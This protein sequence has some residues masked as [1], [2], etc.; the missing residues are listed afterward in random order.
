MKNLKIL[1]GL[2]I[3][4]LM[5]LI[6]TGL[7]INY[8]GIEHEHLLIKIGFI[9]VVVNI[10]LYL[11]ILI[12]SVIKNLIKI[13]TEK[14]HKVIGSKFRTKLVASFLGLTL[15]PSS[16]LF[17]LSNQLID[18][19]IDKWF[20]LEVQRPIDD[21]MYIARAFYLRE[22][23]NILIYANLMA[24]DKN[25][26]K[27]KN[28]F[29]KENDKYLVHVIKK[30]DD[31]D[32]IK[33]AFKGTSDTEIESTKTGDII[34]AVTPVKDNGK[35]SFVIA[36]ETVVP[37]EIVNKMD[38]IRKANNEYNQIK[39]QQNP[40]RFFY[41]LMLTVA[42][43]IIVFLALW[44]SLRIAKS[45]TV[46]IRSL[47]EA[48]KTVAHGDL[49][50]R[51]DL[52]RDDEIGMLINSFNMMLDDLK[53]GKVSLEH[54][55]KESD[56]R[57]LSMEAILEN[58][59]TGVIFL[60]RSGKIIT[61][62]NAACSMLNL[63]RNDIIG[64]SH[65]DFLGRIK[66]DELNAMIRKIGEKDFISK[67]KE[68]HAYIDGRP[69]D[70]RVN[71]TVLKNSR[72][73]IIGILVVF[74]DLTEVITAQRA[75]AWQEV[76]K[77]IT[78][79]IKNPLTPIKLL[80]ER[81]IKK[82][83]AKAEDFGE[84]FQKATKTVIKEVDNLRNLVDGFSRFGK[85]SKINLKP[86]NIN[87]IVEEIAELYRDSSGIKIL[88]SLE[89]IPVIDVDSEQIKRALI[90]L[91]D[92]AVQAKTGT[93][94]IN[95]SFDPSFETIKLEVIDD[96]T[97]IKEEDK[98]KLFLPHFSTKKEGMGLGL[99]IVSTIISKHRGY[100]RIKDNEP[101]GSHFIIELPAGQK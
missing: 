4:S 59:N 46:P 21:S 99:A 65:K 20:S 19:S 18:S 33:N 78:H 92:N 58:I 12:F 42:S 61:M 69:I 22:R 49:D 14:K 40:I 9:F 5:A 72:K 28:K 89:E 96:G 23:E 24:S 85:M 7:V 57:R 56:K 30:P 94:L 44:I 34:R 91:V 47:A 84:V 38:S 41:F 36:V 8:L 54:A 37:L 67:E 75:L 68:L 32:F 13:F 29:K 62:N 79:E 31:T 52:K 93:I 97:G 77:R 88:T 11:L 66:S 60:E 48:T 35:I 3:L 86:Y 2:F 80:T 101:R 16:L 71:I 39:I 26:L 83:N 70:L 100:I 50:F 27:T 25:I 51:I 81:L 53:L 73:D 82:W 45:I 1:I 15:I 87:R 76:A 90:N 6:V 10:V 74:D 95:T 17:I 63:N 64:K 55:Y 98:D 43:L